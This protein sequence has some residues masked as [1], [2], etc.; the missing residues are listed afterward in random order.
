[1]L[2]LVTMYLRTPLSL[3]LSLIVNLF[4]FFFVKREN[5]LLIIHGLIDENVHFSHTS[6]FIDAMAKEVKPYELQIYPSE[7]HS[8]RNLEANQHYETKLLS[9]LQNN[10]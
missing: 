8:L 4:S 10:L 7:R 6:K 3:S 9:F 2:F 1:M 5:R